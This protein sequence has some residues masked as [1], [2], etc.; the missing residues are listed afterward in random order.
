[1]IILNKKFLFVKNKHLK[2]IIFMIIKFF[3]FLFL[4]HNV[5]KK[6]IKQNFPKEC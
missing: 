1:M 3:S 6:N 2:Q 5:K 4:L